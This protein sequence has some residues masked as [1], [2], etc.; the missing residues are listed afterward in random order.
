MKDK[1]LIDLIRAVKAHHTHE[2]TKGIDNPLPIQVERSKQDLNKA[3]GLFSISYYETYLH[4][5]SIEDV[6]SAIRNN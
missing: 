1:M 6:V 5:L 4:K 2:E 3:V